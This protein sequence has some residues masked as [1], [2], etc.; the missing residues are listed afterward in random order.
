[1]TLV[2]FVIIIQIV[3]IAVTTYNIQNLPVTITFQIKFNIFTKLLII[4]IM[5]LRVSSSFKVNT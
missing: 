4:V 2:N 5:A 1:M 3:T